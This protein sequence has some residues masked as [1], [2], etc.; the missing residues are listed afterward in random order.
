MKQKT[1]YTHP[2]ISL[3]YQPYREGYPG[4]D[5]PGNYHLDVKDGA[6]I[7]LT[8]NGEKVGQIEK[9]SIKLMDVYDTSEEKTNN[10]LLVLLGGLKFYPFT[11]WFA[12]FWDLN[13]IK[14]KCELIIDWQEGKSCRSIIFEYTEYDPLST[15]LR[16]KR[17]LQE[18]LNK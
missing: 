8:L 3:A 1:S 11:S 2:N 14:E 7:L 6:I 10:F 9:E 4:L 13:S 5:R 16:T 18:M 17:Y 15:A 12:D